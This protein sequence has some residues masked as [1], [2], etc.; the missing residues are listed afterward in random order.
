MRKSKKRG[1][2]ALSIMVVATTIL[3]LTIL[4]LLTNFVA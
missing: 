3:A 4:F 2:F 1:L